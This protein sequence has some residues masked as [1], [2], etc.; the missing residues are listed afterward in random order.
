MQVGVDIGSTTTKIVAVDQKN[1]EI[2]FSKYKRHN[3]HQ[4]QSVYELLR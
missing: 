3:A 4:I 1:N 2:I